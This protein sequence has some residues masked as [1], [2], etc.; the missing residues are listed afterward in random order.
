MVYFKSD[1]ID[2]S[3]P[4]VNCVVKKSTLQTKPVPS[5]E[6]AGSDAGN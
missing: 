4:L 2:K 3:Q 6:A 5:D 1:A